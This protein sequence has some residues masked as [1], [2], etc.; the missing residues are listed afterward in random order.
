MDYIQLV[1]FGFSCK[2][3]S[4]P[5]FD[6]EPSTFVQA[7]NIGDHWVCVT[8]I[9]SK[10]LNHVYVYDSFYYQPNEELIVQLTSLLRTLIEPDSITINMRPFCKQETGSRTCGYYAL[11][12]ALFLCNGL[13]PS[14]LEFNTETLILHVKLLINEKQTTIIPAARI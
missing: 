2:G 14:G 10:K 8:N 6:P 1:D 11:G 13:D 4:L 5:Q 12:A 7:L 3:K 9:F